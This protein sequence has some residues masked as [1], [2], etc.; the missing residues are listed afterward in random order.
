MQEHVK[1][2]I[3]AIASRYQTRRSAIMPALALVQETADSLHGDI[4]LE[5]ADILD[6]PEIWV[7][8]VATF[9]EMFHTK[10]VGKYHIQLC[11]NVSCM[12]AQAERLM[13][14][15]EEQLKIS[16]GDTTPD[17]MFTLSTVECLGSCNTAPV[18]MV[19]RD[20]H[21]NLDEQRIDELLV[22]MKR[23]TEN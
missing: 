13:Q 12:L 7:F 9:Y 21:E 14:H 10:A 3:N 19:N 23:Q 1:E 6:V 18:M 4:L 15:L 22:Q 20:Y 8:E 17:R 5:V 11:T 2:Q 16:R